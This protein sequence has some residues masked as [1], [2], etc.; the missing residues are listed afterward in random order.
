MIDFATAII[1]V[2]TPRLYLILDDLTQALRGAPD[3]APGEMV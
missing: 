3:Q 1:L 2:I